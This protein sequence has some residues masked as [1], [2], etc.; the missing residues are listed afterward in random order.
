[1][2][3]AA[4][5][6]VAARR[7][8]RTAFT[9]AFALAAGYALALDIPYLPALFALL[10]TSN[11]N[12]PPG[13]KGLLALVVAAMATSG[14]GILLVPVFLEYPV[15]GLLIT[16]VGL[17]VGTLLSVKLAQPAIGT[18]IAMGFTVVPALGTVNDLLAELVVEALGVGIAVAIGCQWIAY[19]VFPED[20]AGGAPEPAATG[21][22]DAPRAATRATLVVMPPFL[23]LLTDPLSFVPV[24]MFALLFAQEDSASSVRAAGRELVASTLLAGLAAIVFWWLLKMNP[25]LWMYA[26]LMLLFT[27]VFSAR[28]CGAVPTSFSTP[29]W[30]NVGKTL[31]I[32]VGPAVS[33]AANGNDVY[34]AFA[35]R[36]GLFV[37]VAVYAWLTFR[38]LAQARARL[39][40]GRERDRPVPAAGVA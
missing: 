31:L 35:I 34:R 33:D 14:I 9:V 24:V 26:L 36:M 40:A 30:L 10:L 12:P 27:T 19:P 28:A 22:M 8:F 7:T 15:T 18:L 6:P 23:L 4:R 20:D 13:A 37:S 25:S 1:M 16:A 38:L 21:P 5:M 17:W 2:S 32:L 39:V 3:M 11:G 29:F